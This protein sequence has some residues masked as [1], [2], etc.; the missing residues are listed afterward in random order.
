MA[1]KVAVENLHERRVPLG[2]LELRL[3]LVV[4]PLVIEPRVGG[5]TGDREVGGVESF[6]ELLGPFMRRVGREVRVGGLN[7]DIV[8]SE[9][10]GQLDGRLQG[11][12]VEYVVEECGFMGCHR[13]CAPTT[14]RPQGPVG[15]HHAVDATS[16]Q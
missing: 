3:G 11:S 6:L 15:D 5:E 4:R 2:L 13:R 8:V 14:R 12:V 1:E 7:F 10:R 16:R 9:F